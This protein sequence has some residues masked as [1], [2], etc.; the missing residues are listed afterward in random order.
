MQVEYLTIGQVSR[1][2]D[3]TPRMLRHYE[4]LGLI[5]TIRKD[6]SAY[7]VYDEK[8]VKRLRQI[9][10]LRKLRIP[11][12]Q[13][14]IILGENRQ[15]H[16]TQRIFWSS[17]EELDREIDSLGKIRDILKSFSER[18][19]ICVRENKSF[20]LLEDGELSETAEKLS[21]SKTALKDKLGLEESEIGDI[22]GKDL[23][24]RIIQVPP[25]TVASYHFIGENPEDAAAAVV[26]EFVKSNGLYGIK[27]DSR[28]F[29]FCNPV[30]GVLED[31]LHGYEIQVTVPED[32]KVAKPLVK[33]KTEG[34]LYAVLTI[35]WGEFQFWRY[36]W[37]WLINNPTYEADRSRIKDGVGCP[38][39]YL[40]WV[41]F[42]HMSC[43]EARF[44]SQMDLMIPVKRRDEGSV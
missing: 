18:L 21:F 25:F 5:E 30:H 39:E 27:P 19:D 2:F 24:V 15:H 4:K 31:E 17:I 38:E 34:G 40:N 43:A 42:C 9:I 10:I 12:K 3:V 35:K 16:L 8:A 26:S 36:F 29:G 13:I 44:E 33:K 20:D 41:Y 11:L 28:M 32:M 6:D 22:P 37:R 14:D 23:N 7:R 1:K